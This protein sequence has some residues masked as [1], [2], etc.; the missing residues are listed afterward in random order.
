MIAGAPHTFGGWDLLSTCSNLWRLDNG[1]A[2]AAWPPYLRSNS[3][4][5]SA[6][7]LPMPRTS[8]QAASRSALGFDVP[9]SQL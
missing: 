8:A 7:R 5:R 4:L 6:S 2:Q 3:N 1:E 9:L